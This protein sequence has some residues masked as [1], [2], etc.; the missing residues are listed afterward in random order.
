VEPG[1]GEELRRKAASALH[2]ALL[3]GAA[4]ALLAAGARDSPAITVAALLAGWLVGSL[5]EYAVHRFVLHGPA[6]A[7]RVHA[8]HHAAPAREQIDP[9][10]YFGPIV[11][12]LLAWA[13]LHALGGGAA[14]A[15]GL[16]AGLC[17]QYSWFRAVHRR[18]HRPGHR[19]ASGRL[20]H[21]HRG[22]HVDLRR[23]FGVTTPFWDRLFRTQRR[24]ART[25]G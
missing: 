6:L 23:N 21:F 25:Q 8:R 2:Y 18:M 11:V 17:L 7:A 13:A 15:G 9:L 14:L 20:A 10:S 1:R 3:V 24:T 4:L 16:T 12:A 5:A 22:H 19:L